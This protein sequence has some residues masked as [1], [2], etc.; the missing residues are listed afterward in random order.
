MKKLLF[1]LVFC[2]P[3]SLTA[4]V[5]FAPAAGVGM[6]GYRQGMSSY[7]T[8]TLPPQPALTAGVLADIKLSRHLYLQSGFYCIA[9][10]FQ[11]EDKLLGG[12][13]SWW[14]K[15]TGLIYSGQIPI[16]L[17]LKTGDGHGGRFT[18][19]AGPYFSSDIWTRFHIKSFDYDGRKIYDTT[20]TMTFPAISPKADIGLGLSVGY[21][22]KNGVFARVFCQQ[23][24]HR[25]YPYD[26]GLTAGYLFKK[27][28]KNSEN[29]PGRIK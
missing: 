13:V 2:L 25:P 4:Q 14:T 15:A 28:S 5:S 21:E 9:K 12:Y 3:L 17:V 20:V 1:L 16:S 18:L 8:Y 29:D 26:Y 22:M 24:L 11:F 7:P 19:G 6:A 10:G 27:K 23:L